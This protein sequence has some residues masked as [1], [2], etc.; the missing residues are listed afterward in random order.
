MIPIVCFLVQSVS[1]EDK[2]VYF[3]SRICYPTSLSSINRSRVVASKFDDI[4]APFLF[5]PSVH[6]RTG[7]EVSSAFVHSVDSW[8]VGHQVTPKVQVESGKRK[9]PQMPLPGRG[10]GVG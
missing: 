9:L 1:K 3:T 7:C 4:L 8:A 5:L 10:W 6:I 2:K